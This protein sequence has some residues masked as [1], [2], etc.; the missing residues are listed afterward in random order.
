LNPGVT[1]HFRTAATNDYGL[2]Y[3]SDQSFTTAR[4]GPQVTTLSA[5]AVTTT[6]ATINGTVNP[7]GSPTTAWFEWWD[8]TPEYGN[9]TPVADLGSGTNA[10]PLSAA[11]AGLNPGVTYHFHITTLRQRTTSR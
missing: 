11:L 5:T 3:G 1:Y 2:A 6:S 9:R 4:L 8:A 7:N 10:L